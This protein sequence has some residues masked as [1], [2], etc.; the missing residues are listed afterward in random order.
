MLYA[1]V[2]DSL[3]ELRRFLASVPWVAVKAAQ[4]YPHLQV[5]AFTVI[6]SMG[7]QDLAAIGVHGS[8]LKQVEL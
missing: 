2:A 3:F 5:L 8:V 1:A 6:T 4:P 7:W